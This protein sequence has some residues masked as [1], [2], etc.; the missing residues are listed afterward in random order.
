MEFYDD[1]VLQQCEETFSAEM[2][3][4]NPQAF[5]YGGITPK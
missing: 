1:N 3:G 4:K 5:A 2:A